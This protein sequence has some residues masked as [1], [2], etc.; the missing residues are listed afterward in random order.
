MRAVGEV[1]Q[2]ER[3]VLPEQGTVLKMGWE[4]FPLW[5]N[6]I[7]SILG[8]AR[9]QVQSP[10]RHSVLGIWRCPSC[11]L[12]HDSGSDLIPDPGAP[13]AFG[14]PKMVKRKKKGMTVAVL[15]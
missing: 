13:Y 9:M 6:G 2:V 4:E 14:W 12:G 11:G 1:G 5:L 10:A 8:A 3:G 7:S 15:Q